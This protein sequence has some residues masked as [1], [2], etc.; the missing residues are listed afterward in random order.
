MIGAAISAG[1]GLLS[2]YFGAQ[3]AKQ[4]TDR[5]IAENKRLADYQYSKELEMWN[6]ANKYNS[7]A[8]QMERFKAAGLNPNLIYGQ[9]NAGNTAT[10]PKYQAP[11]VDYQYRPSVDP[12]AMLGAYQD[13]RMKQAQTKAAEAQANEAEDYWK[14]KTGGAYEKMMLDYY[15][16][17]GVKMETDVKMGNF[18]LNIGGKA[19]PWQQYQLDIAK[20]K[21]NT[22]NERAALIRQQGAAY[23]ANTKLM[24]LEIDNFLTKMWSGIITQGANTLLKFK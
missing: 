6:A 5:T 9:G 2:Q 10:I 1:A 13:F 3:T 21:A 11:K 24:Q 7:P 8:S 16:R 14:N 18:D 15:K 17:H 19:T 22:E 23:Q 12:L 4:N 20:A